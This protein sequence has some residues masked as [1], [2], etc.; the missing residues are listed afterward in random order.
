MT[1]SSTRRGFP[2]RFGS[3]LLLLLIGAIVAYDTQKHGS[4]EGKISSQ[5]I[6]LIALCVDYFLS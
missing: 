6:T 4:F 1:S 5:T 2:W 3:F